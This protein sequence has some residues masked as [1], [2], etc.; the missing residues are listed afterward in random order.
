MRICTLRPQKKH[1]LQRLVD[2]AMLTDPSVRVS[3]RF[4]PQPREEALPVMSKLICGHKTGILSIQLAG[5]DGYAHLVAQSS[6][7]KTRVSRC[8]WARL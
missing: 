1:D 6:A 2:G 5:D 3:A 8:F 7:E 4:L